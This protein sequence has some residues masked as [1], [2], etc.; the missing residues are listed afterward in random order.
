MSLKEKLLSWVPTAPLRKREPQDYYQDQSSGVYDSLVEAYLDQTSVSYDRSKIYKDIDQMDDEI[1]AQAMDMVADDATQM[2]Y[3]RKKS[4][5]VNSPSSKRKQIIENLFK[6]I[7]L[8]ER[9]WL[10]TR[11]VDKYGDFFLRLVLD[12]ENKKISA[13]RDTYHPREV[14]RLEKNGKLVGFLKLTGNPDQIPDNPGLWIH[15]RDPRYRIKEDLLPTDFFMKWDVDKNP[16]YGSSG[17][18]KVR[19]VDKQ[20][21]LSED[22]L[23]LS[24]IARSQYVQIHYVQ[25]GDADPK[26]GKKITKNYEN[27]FTKRK[28][29][30]YNNDQ[31]D[32][33]RSNLSYAD[34]VFVPVRSNDK[35]RSEVKEVGG[36][37]DVTSIVDIEMLNKKRFGSLGIPKEY[38][39]FDSGMSYNTLM[40]LD[41]RYARKVA[42]RQRSM[43]I[44]LTRLA[45]IELYLHGEEWDAD[46]FQIMMSSVSSTDQ[47]ERIDSLNAILDA[48]ERMSRFFQNIEKDIDQIYLY[49]YIVKQYLQLNDFDIDKLFNS[50]DN[51]DKSIDHT[52]LGYD[53]PDRLMAKLS[54]IVAENPELR[55][56]F[57]NFMQEYSLLDENIAKLDSSL[58]ANSVTNE[59][60]EN[61]VS[62]SDSKFKNLRKRKQDNSNKDKENG[63]EE[64]SDDS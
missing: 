10:W 45:Q 13:V 64:A 33:R 28:A 60:L 50:E 52:D 4:V 23:V 15:F 48:G 44:G 47:L 7:D 59:E 6:R 53:S 51:S 61:L 5:W 41:P 56:P 63:S 38:M 20:I 21:R 58:R 46:S 31:A 49:R 2:D 17:Y 26:E 40:Q 16:R 39:S 34:R 19:K 36:D 25:V 62:S 12:V 35:G 43:I 24:R 55:E 57:D 14:C 54:E 32:M 42:N 18:V 3:R 27:L 9:I 30:D 29:V 1:I 37:P 22:S 8:E 11:E